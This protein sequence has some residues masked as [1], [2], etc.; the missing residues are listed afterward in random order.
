MA[1]IFIGNLPLEMTDSVLIELLRSVE[2]VESAVI[3]RD[4]YSGSSRGYG[5]AD[6]LTDQQASHIIHALNQKEISGKIVVVNWAS[7]KISVKYS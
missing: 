6:V 7:P 4:H 1:K 2:P 3:V 5:F